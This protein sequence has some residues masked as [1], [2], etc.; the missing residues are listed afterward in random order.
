LLTDLSTPLPCGFKGLEGGVVSE[1]ETE[2]AVVVVLGLLDT[3]T[4]V[5]GVV[6][7]V[8]TADDGGRLKL[9][10]V[11]V[12]EFPAPHFPLPLLVLVS[13]NSPPGIEVI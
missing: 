4:G 2:T 13:T 7:E 10:S 1:V 5:T 6:E 11:T 8:G 3:E 9:V 12:P